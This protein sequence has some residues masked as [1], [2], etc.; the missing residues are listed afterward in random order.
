MRFSYRL[1]H[2]NDQNHPSI[3]TH[4]NQYKTLV[5]AH[6]VHLR[7]ESGEKNLT[8]N[9]QMVIKIITETIWYHC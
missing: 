5:T 2:R 7:V 6:Y 3:Q 9:A 1:S 8:D 4:G